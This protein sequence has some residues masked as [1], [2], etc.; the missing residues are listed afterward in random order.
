MQSFARRFGGGQ[1]RG[2]TKEGHPRDRP[3]GDNRV[4]GEKP[5]VV[6]IN[7]SWA[8]EQFTK[9]LKSRVAAIAIQTI[10]GHLVRPWIAA[11]GSS[12]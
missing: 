1:L 6:N 12:P 10:T 7:K 11:L 2:T 5:L 4:A 9:T 8:L 3:N